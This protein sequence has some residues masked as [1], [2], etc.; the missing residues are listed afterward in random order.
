MNESQKKIVG[1]A[2]RMLSAGAHRGNRMIDAGA[3][4]AEIAA[5]V[6]DLE[7]LVRGMREA[8]GQAAGAGAV[9]ATVQKRKAG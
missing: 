9:L 4:Y 6:V 3:T 1:G 8:L 5:H 7:Q 2:F